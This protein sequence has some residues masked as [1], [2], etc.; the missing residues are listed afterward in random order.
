MNFTQ[1]IP[2]DRRKKKSLTN[3]YYASITPE[4]KD[5]KTVPKKGLIFLWMYA[6]ILNKIAES[7]NVYVKKGIHHNQVIPPCK[8]SSTF[9]SQSI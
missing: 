2:E 5:N 9:K 1:S 8:P 4:Q 3:S 7:S 6:K